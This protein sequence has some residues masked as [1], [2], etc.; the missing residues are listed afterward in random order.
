MLLR[1]SRVYNIKLIPNSFQKRI[2]RINVFKLT[3]KFLSGLKF[4]FLPSSLQMVDSFGISFNNFWTT[5]RN[6]TRTTSR[7]K[8]GKQGYSKSLILPDWRGSGASRRITFPWITTKWA[9]LFGTTTA[10]TFYG[11]SKGN[12]IVTSKLKI[13]FFLLLVERNRNVESVMSKFRCCNRTFNCN[14]FEGV[15][16]TLPVIMKVV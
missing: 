16:E 12:G 9:E 4:S 13:I 2:C 10:S 11:R 14:I 15:E 5:L 8:A 7:G 1:V 6:G 3:T